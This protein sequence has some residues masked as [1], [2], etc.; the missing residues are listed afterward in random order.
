MTSHCTHWYPAQNRPLTASSLKP[1]PECAPIVWNLGRTAGTATAKGRCW[2]RILDWI[3]APM[4]L[5]GLAAAAVIFY[6]NVYC[7][8]G[9]LVPGSAYQLLQ[10][11]S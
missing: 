10:S 1:L 11:L 6:Y 9:Q 3:E 8:L 5:A 2:R 4:A 7:C